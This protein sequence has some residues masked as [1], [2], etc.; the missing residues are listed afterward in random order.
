[1]DIQKELDI[2]QAAI[3]SFERAIPLIVSPSYHQQAIELI[4]EGI[5]YLE[6]S[7]VDQYFSLLSTTIKI[8]NAGD[9][10]ILF[11]VTYQAYILDILELLVKLSEDMK[12]NGVPSETG[13]K[14]IQ[15]AGEFLIRLA[16]RAT[17]RYKMTITFDPEFEAKYVR[18]F[19]VLRELRGSCRFLNLSPD[20]TENEGANL[21]AGL[22][23]EVLSQ[24]VPGVLYKK[25]GSVLDVSGVQIFSE[26]KSVPVLILDPPTTADSF[27]VKISQY[28]Q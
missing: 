10:A 27:D 19:M 14:D 12:Q 6:K 9:S 28:L 11:T 7:D 18:A 16:G 2:I 5:G 21:D 15:I 3:G 8:L 26:T 4:G 17:N 22:D 13:V 24:E 1:M 25:A 20:I 23:I